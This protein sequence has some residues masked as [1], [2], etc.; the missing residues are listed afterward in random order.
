MARSTGPPP[1]P[2]ATEATGSPGEGEPYRLVPLSAS[3]AERWDELIGSYETRQLFHRRVW[4][5]FLAASQGAR[6]RFWSVREG[7]AL[8]GYFCAGILRRGPFKI[9]GS[10]LR[11]W[12][13][14]FLG[15][16]VRPDVDQ[17][18]LL[19]AIDALAKAEGIAVVEIEH[20]LLDEHV[21][22][23][24]GYEP[25]QTATYLVDLRPGDTDAMWRSMESTRRNSVRKAERRGLTV[26]RTRD[27]SV[28]D[29]FYDQY[30]DVMS[31]KGLVPS[32]PRRVPQVLVHHLEPRDALF[33]LR[34]RDSDGRVLATGLFPHDEQTVYFWGG[35]SW[36]DALH[37]CPND[38]LHW[39]LMCMAAERGLTQ[40]N[41]SGDG[42]FK[43]KFGGRLLRLRRWRKC[44]W[45][46]ANRA[47]RLYELYFQTQTLVRGRLRSAF[48]RLTG[49][50][51]PA[52][53]RG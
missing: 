19:A 24:S 48:S 9:L 14:N 26:E 45:P 49:K 53:P 10:P 36:H 34:V 8:V 16:V 11:G 22:A 35:A 32:Y 6:I 17:R 20:P 44:F 28:A 1:R 31:R 21:L 47:L 51:G 39:S 38:L 4:L 18:R 37:L 13:T 25:R 33:A 42:R 52:S 27:A 29:E 23:A 43:R 2:V 3:E 30:I 40:Y 15:P 12:G 41:M 46:S 5:D 7:D 50:R